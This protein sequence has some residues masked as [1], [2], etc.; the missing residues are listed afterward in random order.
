MTY[1]ASNIGLVLSEGATV[2]AV[3]CGCSFYSFYFTY[4]YAGAARERYTSLS[5]GD[6]MAAR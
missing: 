1:G 4:A 3:P 6:A 2:P 5:F